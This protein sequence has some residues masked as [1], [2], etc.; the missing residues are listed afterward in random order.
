MARTLGT[1]IG[2]IGWATAASMIV[3]VAAVPWAGAAT[4]SSGYVPGGASVHRATTATG[5][6]ID[7]TFEF[8]GAERTYHLYVPSHLPK[9]PRPLLVG[10]H[11]GLGSGPQFEADT[12]FDGLAQANGFIAVYPDGTPIRAG[13]DHLVWNAGGCCGIADAA[14][15]NV[16]DVGFVAAL[17]RHLE[18]A[19]DIDPHRVF[20]TGHSNGALLAYAVACQD[21]ATV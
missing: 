5:R 14:H 2:R 15:E 16:D 8:A 3:L 18:S 9:G 6:R 4:R 21:A 19:Y 7:A 11:G 13:S 1:R 20:L 17:V 12:G 10:L